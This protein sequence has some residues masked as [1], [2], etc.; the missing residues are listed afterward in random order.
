VIYKCDH[1]PFSIQKRERAFLIGSNPKL[2]I[3]TVNNLKLKK[4]KVRV[5]IKN[6][7]KLEILHL[8]SAM[9]ED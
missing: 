7:V 3:F 5:F 4:F 1:N 6:E 8:S 2:K 9:S